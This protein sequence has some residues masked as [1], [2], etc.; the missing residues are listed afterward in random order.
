MTDQVAAARAALEEEA[1]IRQQRRDQYNAW[2]ED[3]A[4]RAWLL[5]IEQEWPAGSKWPVCLSTELEALEKKTLGTGNEQELTV[6]D[7]RRFSISE[8]YGIVPLAGKERLVTDYRP[9]S[10]DPRCIPIWPM[11]N[12]AL[13]LPLSIT[14]SYGYR[15]P[16][17]A[18]KSGI[19]PDMDNCPVWE[20]K[21]ER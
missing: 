16:S 20:P 15:L 8:C 3:L 5:E 1:A 7:S 19:W 6:V 4:Q 9:F 18:Q 11:P 21:E 13:P 17:E 2:L 10:V 14:N 12:T